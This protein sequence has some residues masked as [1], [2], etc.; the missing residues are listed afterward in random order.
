MVLWDFISLLFKPPF[1][2][3]KPVAFLANFTDQLYYGSD[4]ETDSE[5]SNTRLGDQW[6][7][8]CCPAD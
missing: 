8:L 6:K 1:P 7:G 3:L 2:D 5:V 4:E